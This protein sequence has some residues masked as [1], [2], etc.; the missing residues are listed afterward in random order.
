MTNGALG[1]FAAIQDQWRRL[2]AAQIEK[3][4]E[5]KWE[6]PKTTLDNKSEKPLVV[7]VFFN[8]NRKLSAKKTENLQA[9]MNTKTEKPK[10]FGT[11]PD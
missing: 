1:G 3:K 5:A 11:K 8:E 9:A 7:V 4:P 10:F 6:K 2:I